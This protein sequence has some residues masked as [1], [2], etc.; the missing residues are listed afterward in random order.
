LDL[1]LLSSVERAKTAGTG[2]AALVTT[3]ETTQTTTKTNAAAAV[4]A[5]GDWEVDDAAADMY[6]HA[7]RSANIV[8]QQHCCH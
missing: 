6:V 4:A 3:D 8:C 1:V 7:G 5:S 2:I